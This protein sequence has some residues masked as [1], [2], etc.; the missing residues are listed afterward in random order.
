MTAIKDQDVALDVGKEGSFAPAS[1]PL[2]TIPGAS[3]SIPQVHESRLLRKID[4]HV[5]PI[6]FLV[7]VVA[8]LDRVNISNALTL[9]L[10]AELSLMGQQPNISLTIFFVPYI[11]FEIPSNILMKRFSPH[12]WLSGSILVFGVIC[13]A[14]GFVRSY[15]GILATRFFLG[16]AE[17]GIFPGSFYL[18]SFWYKQAESQTRFTVY[19]CSTMFASA[20]GSLL[21]SAIANMDGIQGLSGWRW[22]F[23]LEG[24]ATVVVAALAFFTISDFPLEAKWLTEDERVFVVNKTKENESSSQPVTIRDVLSFLTRPKHWIGAIMYFSNLIP[25]Y[26]L[27]YFTPTIVQGLGY[28]SIQ[29]QLHSVPPFAAAFGL[30]V[31]LAIFSDRMRVRSPFIFFNICL[32]IAG[33]VM[34]MKI[35]GVENFSAEYAGLCLAGM[36]SLGVGGNI[37]CW[38]VMNLRGHTERAIGTAWMICFG[39]IGGIVAT[40]AFQKKDAPLYHTGY[41]LVLSM[42]ALCFVSCAAYALIIWHER[43]AASLRSSGDNE[44]KHELY[45]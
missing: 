3:I 1:G 26:S 36:G 8:F 21:A 20:F 25:A 30:T 9:G 27:V 11:L 39:N 24:V 35:H 40:F 7:Y 10:P 12:V 19:W 16:L 13:I 28:S 34:C 15:S 23:I 41:S 4:F 29:T 5:L 6:L 33:T 32:L 38:Y 18:I 43:K 42:G 37:I 14:Q 2:P 22:V 45:L 44:V 17:S 31:I